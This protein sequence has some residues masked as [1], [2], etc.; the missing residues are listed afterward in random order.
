MK[1]SKYSGNLLTATGILHLLIVLILSG[2]TYIRMIADGLFNTIAKD[3]VRAAA[4][5]NFVVGI[6]LILLGITL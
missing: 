5:W 4:T 1:I 3:Y 2:D 6:L